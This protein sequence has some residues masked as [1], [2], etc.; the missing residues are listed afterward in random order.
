MKCSAGILIAFA[1]VTLLFI[2]TAANADAPALDCGD[3]VYYQPDPKDLY[4]LPHDKYYT[5]GMERKWAADQVV[6]FVKLT[7]FKLANWQA[8]E[9]ND[10]YIHLLDNDAPLGVKEYPDVDGGGDNFVGQ[11]PL[12]VQYH[13]VSHIAETKTYEFTLAQIAE[14]NTNAAD[15]KFSLGID[16]DCHFNNRGFCLKV[17]TEL[18]PEPATM[19]LLSL[20][21]LP[22]LKRFRRRKKA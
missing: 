19:G 3:C 13:N 20:G 14:L 7:I 22:L 21:A 15:G 1:I 2:S 8:G 12:L 11:G 4:D 18:I 5:W 17:C 16:P 6:V 10:L 9:P